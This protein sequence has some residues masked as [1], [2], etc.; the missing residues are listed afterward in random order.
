MDLQEPNRELEPLGFVDSF[1]MAVS[2]LVEREA[3]D[4]SPFNKKILID[5]VEV[6]FSHWRFSALRH[7]LELHTESSQ[8][9]KSKK[10]LEQFLM[11]KF[12]EFV[13][14]TL[15]PSLYSAGQRMEL[16]RDKFVAGFI[17]R[18]NELMKSYGMKAVYINED[19]EHRSEM[20]IM[21]GVAQPIMLAKP[22]IRRDSPALAQEMSVKVI[23]GEVPADS[24]GDFITEETEPHEVTMVPEGA[25]M[26]DLSGLEEES[27]PIPDQV[28]LGRWKSRRKIFVMLAAAGLLLAARH[29]ASDNFGVDAD[30]PTDQIVKGHMVYD[31][32]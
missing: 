32:E 17:G 29:C 13:T 16:D 1:K 25:F 9:E 7:A 14:T 23:L 21:Y 24:E 26:I 5:A 11:W 27:P 6:A 28:G 10:K 22:G 19:D 30:Y 20:R 12:R 3:R 31:G 15:Y 18:L 8:T 4:M 2:D